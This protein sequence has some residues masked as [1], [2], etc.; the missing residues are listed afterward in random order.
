MA[1]FKD[2]NKVRELLV[3]EEDAALDEIK[4][5]YRK[6]AYEYY[7]DKCREGRKKEC[8]EMFKRIST[9]NDIFK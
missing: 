6:L 5:T 7:P 1:N 4:K 8:E 2:I 9:A 3:L